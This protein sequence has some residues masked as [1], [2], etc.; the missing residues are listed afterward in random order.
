MGEW[1]RLKIIQIINLLGTDVM[2]QIIFYTLHRYHRHNY[3]TLKKNM[4]QPS[5]QR[6]RH[7][8]SHTR[9]IEKCEVNIKDYLIICDVSEM[10]YARLC[11]I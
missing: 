3:I 8:M 9:S 2:N 6:L 1:I 5:V 11:G 7:A 10:L 4:S